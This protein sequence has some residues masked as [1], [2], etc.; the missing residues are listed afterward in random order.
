MTSLSNSRTFASIPY[1]LRKKSLRLWLILE[2]NATSCFKITAFMMFPL[3]EKLLELKS[4]N[5]FR[6]PALHRSNSILVSKVGLAALK[7][8]LKTPSLK[9]VKD[10][11]TFTRHQRRLTNSVSSRSS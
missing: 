3:R 11:L 10:G 8:S 5:K 6:V 2:L 4:S 9:L 7:K 1:L